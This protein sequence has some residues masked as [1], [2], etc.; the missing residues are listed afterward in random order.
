ME[1]LKGG[2]EKTKCVAWR[3][4]F[5]DGKHRSSSGVHAFHAVVVDE[6]LRRARVE[7]GDTVDL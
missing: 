2:T 5:A 1:L 6:S 4:T 3:S 7:A